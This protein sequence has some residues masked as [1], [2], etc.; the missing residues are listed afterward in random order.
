MT[1]T[2]RET[3]HTRAL[4]CRLAACEIDNETHSAANLRRMLRDLGV[5][6]AQIARAV[7]VVK[8]ALAQT[9]RQASQEAPGHTEV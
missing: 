5:D 1:P 8:D 9:C 6:E 3:N 7:A 2:I 4:L